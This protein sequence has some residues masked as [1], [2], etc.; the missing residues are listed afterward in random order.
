VEFSGQS[1]KRGSP[2]TS[3]AGPLQRFVMP[4]ERA[5][6]QQTGVWSATSSISG[7][8]AELHRYAA[9]AVSHVI[10]TS[11]SVPASSVS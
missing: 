8:A 6:E 1:Q 7:L 2:D 4:H 10:I 5:A 11:H 3:D 9:I